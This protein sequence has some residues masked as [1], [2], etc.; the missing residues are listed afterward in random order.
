MAG[1][2]I[3]TVKMPDGSYQ[4]FWL[5]NPAKG[6]VPPQL[7]PFLFKKGHRPVGHNPGNPGWEQLHYDKRTKTT[8]I[9]RTD[10]GKF[11]KGKQTTMAG[12]P[13]P[14][15]NP[16]ELAI[17]NPHSGHISHYH[18]TG[19]ARNDPG[20]KAKHNP[21]FLARFMPSFTP[22]KVN[23]G[24]FV[25]GGAGALVDRQVIPRALSFL[26]AAGFLAWFKQGLGLLVA[27][28]VLLLVQL[29]GGNMIFRGPNARGYVSAYAF[30]G[31]VSILASGAEMGLTKAG[32]PVL[33][34]D[35][36]MERPGNPLGMFALPKAQG[37]LGL[38]QGGRSAAAL[39]ALAASS[40]I[41]SQ[42]EAAGGGSLYPSSS[43]E[44]LGE[45]EA[46]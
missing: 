20:R 13:A 46:Y 7:R 40:E 4:G 25:S 5:T 19:P 23:L 22:P 45:D 9:Y 30:G 14:V 26:P 32:V 36:E 38:F 24:G 6:K 11:K 29:V 15:R 8:P 42:I 21:G 35:A 3:E 34:G 43:V 18:I 37:G 31:G 44:D 33:I 2:V 12:R 27:R 28:A 16:A 10:E 17:L 39:Q 41:P 1:P